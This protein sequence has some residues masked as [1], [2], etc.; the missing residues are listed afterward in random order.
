MHAS[1]YIDYSLSRII[2][3]TL[4]WSKTHTITLY[5]HLIAFSVV[6]ASLAIQIHFPQSCQM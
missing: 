2:T 4:T 5:L 1:L 6:M 3:T